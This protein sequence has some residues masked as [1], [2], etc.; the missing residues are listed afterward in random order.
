VGLFELLAFSA[1]SSGKGAWFISEHLA[2]KQRVRQSGAVYFHKAIT[3]NNQNKRYHN[4]LGLAYLQKGQFDLAFEHVKLA[5]DEISANHRLAKLLYREGKYDLARKYQNK[6]IQLEISAD[7][8]ASVPILSKKKFSDTSL[9]VEEKYPE[10]RPAAI[11][12]DSDQKSSEEEKGP[13]SEYL[14]FSRSQKEYKVLAEIEVLNGNGIEGMARRLGNYLKKKGFNVTRLRNA[15]SF[16]RIESKVFCDS[17]QVEDAYRLMQEIPIHPN[18]KNIIELKV[19]DNK[20]RLLIS[21]D[22]VPHDDVISRPIKEVSLHPYSI[23]LSSCRQW[24][25]V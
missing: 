15:N 4:N 14:P 24:N 9:K 8:T 18:M 19:L 1:F 6:A 17:S 22:I 3:L 5:E 25:S 12:S 10:S 20:I 16:N 23:L 13:I 11:M 21:K 7:K 2:F